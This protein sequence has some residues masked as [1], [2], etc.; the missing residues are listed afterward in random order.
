MCT[1]VRRECAVRAQA[2]LTLVELV[3][4]IVIV[5]IAVVGVLSVLNLTTRHSADPQ[6]RKQALSIAEGLLEE[7]QLARFTHCDV[8]DATADTAAIAAVGAGNCTTTVENVGPE[9]GNARPFDNVNDYV[10]A[11]GAALAYPADAADRPFPDGYNATVTITPEALGGIASDAAAAANT[12]VLR[13][14]VNVSYNNGNDSVRLDGY[15]TRY[16]PNAL[17]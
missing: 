9:D 8:V 15:R 10:N 12:N 17:P 7:V 14:T 4:F 2:G 13:I 1:S 11:Y 3:M 5:G 6:L 16:A